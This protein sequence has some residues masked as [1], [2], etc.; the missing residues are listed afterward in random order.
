MLSFLDAVRRMGGTWRYDS[1]EGV[2]FVDGEVSSLT[3]LTV[4][5]NIYPGFPTDLL[6]PVGVAMTQAKGVSRIFERL[7]EGR[8]AYLYELEKMGA[9][10]EILNSHQALIIGPTALRG[11]TVVS[12]DVRAGAAMVLAGL[13]AT[14]ETVVTDV[15]YIERGYDRLEL[16]LKTLG[17]KIVRENA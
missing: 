3:A 7:Y 8:M 6:A 17:A 11:R 2:L 4:K 12:N 13:I 9:Q 14:G 16:K 10:I 1:A 15:Q 5:T